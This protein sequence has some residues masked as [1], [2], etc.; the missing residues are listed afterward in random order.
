MLRINSIS[1][2]QFKNYAS[3]K[4]LFSERVVGIHGMNGRG[5]T[6]LLDAIY[7]LCFT[8]SYFTRSDQQNVLNG[9]SGFRVQGTA[10][11][12]DNDHDL[13]C[14]LR[15]TGKKE[16]SIDGDMYDRLS[17]HVG[18][19]PAVIIAPDDVYIITEASEE[20]RRLI[21]AILSQTDHQYLL[22]LMDYNRVLQQRNSYLR[23]TE[24]QRLDRR[25]MDVYDEQLVKHGSYV[26]Q[27]RKRFLASFIPE[28]IKY[29]GQIAGEH[30]GLELM[31]KSQ[32][33]DVDMAELIMNHRDRDMASQRTNAGTHRDDLEILLNERSFK[34]MASQGQRKSLLFALKLAEFEALK[35]NK[36]F[37]P[38]LLLDDVFE[39]LDEHRMHNLLQ[40][41]CLQED[42]QLFITDTHGERIKEHMAKIG[43]TFQLVQI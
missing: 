29:Y 39:K 23:N 4:F 37:S 12:A 28:V 33:H 34:S 24:F 21:D 25:L 43:V 7:Y 27:V 11:L 32:L 2:F 1:L 15:E 26:F 35:K 38:L 36:G 18:K 5:K 14:V 41:V 40:H 16:F 8:K 17:E 13:V 19:F 42:V 31:Y 20:R 10:Q 22:T 30:E 9:A 6:N 3:R